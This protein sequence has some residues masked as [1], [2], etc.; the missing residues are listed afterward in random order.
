MDY[1]KRRTMAN[2]FIDKL[3]NEGDDLE[4]IVFKVDTKFG[5]GEKF[6]NKRIEAIERLS[7]NVS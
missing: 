1:Y 3:I 6:V 5:F 7:E 4:L 2:L